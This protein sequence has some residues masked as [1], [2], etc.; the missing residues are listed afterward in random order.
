MEISSLKVLSSAAG[1]YVGRTYTELPRGGDLPYSRESG[2]F[3]SREDALKEL[4]ILRKMGY[5]EEEWL[6]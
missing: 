2:Y 6:D 5:D 1:Y 3:R 4:A